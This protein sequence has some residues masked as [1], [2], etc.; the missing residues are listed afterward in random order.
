[1][2]PLILLFWTPCDVCPGFQSPYLH[3]FS[4]ACN[5]FLRIT[6]GATPDDCL[7][8]PNIFNPYTCRH[9]LKHWWESNPRPNVPQYNAFNCLATPT[10]LYTYL[11]FSYLDKFVPLKNFNFRKKDSKKE[12]DLNFVFIFRLGKGSLVEIRRQSA[13]WRGWRSCVKRPP[14]WWNSP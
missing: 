11:E 5:G 6:S 8:Q 14:P 13:R 4:L 2:G 9:I 12:R 3:A 10:R 1:M 7:W